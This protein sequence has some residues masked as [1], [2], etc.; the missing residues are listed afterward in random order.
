MSHADRGVTDRA[1]S[2]D[3]ATMSAVVVRR[4]GGPE[5]LDLRRVPR[6]VPGPA[7]VQV[8]VT[9]AGVNPL[10]WKTRE[11]G[12][13][14]G[15]P[16]FV[17]GADL[18][19]VVSA[20]GDGV[21]R[22]DV[23]DRVFGMPRFPAAAGA[24]AQYV[25]A[26]SRQLARIPD[27]VSDVAAAALP[28]AGLTAWQALVDT[29]A[30]GRGSRVLVTGAGGGIGHLAV[31]IARARGAWVAAAARPSRHTLLHGYGP[32]VVLDYTELDRVHDVDVVLELAGGDVPLRTLPAVR[33]GGLLLGITSGV[34]AARRAAAGRV[35]V[36]W[37]LV[38]PDRS[39]L[40]TLADLAA[41]GVVRPHVSATF[42][43]Q[44]AAAAH[45][46]LRSRRAEGKL[47]LTVGMSSACPDERREDGR[48]RRCRQSVGRHAGQ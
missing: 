4:L 28:M 22:F 47:V 7:E 14:L 5:V 36:R 20:V 41:R 26:P 35:D 8:R 44:Q 1:P 24:Y 29:V 27:G 9:A 11:T 43:L 3:P 25:T 17:L 34:E 23:G 48:A 21:T 40:E 37:M 12:A 16:P 2:R 10:D 18:A 19:G 45:E 13:F 31:Q 39:E 15:R 42:P 32:D 38:E 6:P 46:L 30:V 33:D